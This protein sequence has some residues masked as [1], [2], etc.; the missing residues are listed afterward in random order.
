MDIRKSL[1]SLLIIF[2]VLSLGVFIYK[3]FTSK[4]ES[5]AT[6]VAETKNDITSV[7]GKSLPV[8][9]SQPSKE[10]VKKQKEGIPA[11]QLAV[12]SHHQKVIAY[13]F[14]GTFRCSTCQT[15]E[16]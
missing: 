7:S 10:L 15:I 11:S 12:K 2:V 13:Y 4:S 16:K 5:N 14:H 1:K 8:Q 6:D 9:E 3:E